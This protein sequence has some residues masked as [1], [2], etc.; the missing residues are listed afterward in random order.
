MKNRL[1]CRLL[2]LFDCLLKR[3]EKRKI[4]NLSILRV[5]FYTEII[6]ITI[7]ISEY[8]IHTYID[9][10]EKEVSIIINYD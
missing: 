1:L 3:K 6:T 5:I 4:K 7:T 2:L 8:K 9:I 10:S